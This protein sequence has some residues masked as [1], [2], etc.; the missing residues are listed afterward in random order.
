MTINSTD[1]SVVIIMINDGPLGNEFFRLNYYSI[2]PFFTV[3]GDEA[4]FSRTFLA[5]HGLFF[6][7][8]MAQQLILTL[9]RTLVKEPVFTEPTLS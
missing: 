7:D 5:I 6:I 3:G 4:L 9:S 8:L 1:M 2:G